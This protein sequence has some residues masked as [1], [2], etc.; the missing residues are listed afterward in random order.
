MK[1]EMNLN[2]QIKVELTEHGKKVLIETYK[3]MSFTCEEKKYYGF[4]LWEFASIFGKEF[5]NGQVNPSILGNKII[6][7]F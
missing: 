1:I 2:D 4:S 5:Y 3:G 6:I 7:E